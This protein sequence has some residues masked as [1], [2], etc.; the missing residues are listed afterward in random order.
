MKNL[1]TILCSVAALA[2]CG[3][4][5]G[6][7]PVEYSQPVG[8]N[9]KVKSSDVVNGTISIEKGINTESS[10]P[11]G[12]FIT[13]A[14]NELGGV[15]PG[16]IELTAATLL[17]GGNAT[18]VVG[19][20]EIFV[21]QVEVVFQMNDTNNTFPAATGMLV[22]TDGSG[23]IELM[24]TFTSAGANDADYGKILGG[25][26]KVVLR[27]PAH[28]NFRTAGADA[29]VQTTLTFTAFELDSP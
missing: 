14:R 11:Y 29:D 3:D 28:A 9:L 24:P 25:S 8:I 5:G 23:P 6:T 1:S 13:A 15:D 7:V 18:G 17:L 27:G 4:D 20:G 12:A 19:L 2:A 16:R 22:A 10:N 26:F 21:G